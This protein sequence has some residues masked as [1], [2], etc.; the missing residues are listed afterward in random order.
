[1]LTT[2][3]GS[4]DF[5]DTYDGLGDQLDE[6]DDAFNDDT[7]GGGEPAA[8]GKKPVGKDFDFFGHTAKVSDAI[9]E[10]QL[11][12]SRQAPVSRVTPTT[13]NFS[14]PPSKPAR[15]GYE[16]YKEPEY[17]PD[18]QVDASLW[19]VAPKQP[20]PA[21]VQ[22]SAAASGP[23]SGG[24]KMM[25]LEE[26]EAA[27]RAQAKKPAQPAPQAPAQNYAGPPQPQ[28]SQPP[29][30]YEQAYAQQRHQQHPAQISG[31]TR[32]EPRAAHAGQPVQPVQILQRSQAPPSQPTPPAGP[33]QPTQ[34]LQNPNRH[35]GEQQRATP[36]QHSHHSR[37]SGSRNI[38]THP[39]QLAALSEVERNAFL[40]EDAKRAKR[41]HKIFLL[42]KDNG[43]MTPQDKNFITRIQLQQLVTA[44]G[45][46]NEHS[47]DAGLSEDFYYQVH[48]QI[49]GGPRQHPGQPLSNFAQ[50]Y[51][52]QTGGRHGGMRRQARGGDNHMQRMEQ[53]VQ[54]AVEAAKNKPKNKQLVIEGS[55]GKISFSNAKT[56]KPLLNIKRA[57]SGAD[58]NRPGSAAR[59]RKAHLAGVSGSDRKTVLTDIENVYNTLMQMEDHDRHIPPPLSD[60]IDPELVGRHMD[61]REM[62]L[63]LNQQLWKQL[64][65]HEPIGATT[66][67]PFIAFLSFSKGKKAIPRVFRHIT[68]EQRTTILTMI[69]L[70]LDQLDVV[71]NGQPVSGETQLNA[72]L[73]ENVDLFSS[74]VMPSLFQY[75]SEADLDIVTGVLGLILTINVDVVARSRV[76]V[77]M[78]TM[79]LSR[80]ELIKQGGASNEQ[81]WDQW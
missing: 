40:M 76:G 37:P 64:K 31:L 59:D 73:R 65:V 67:H 51:L 33:S 29:Q 30:Q 62:G 16:R 2:S 46:P 52:F 19:G 58:G 5:E 39:G 22:E 54:R 35:S 68:Q 28:Y 75:L 21:F 38:I 8:I 48:N 45:N 56:P 47:T 44:T 20:A 34:I 66:I 70:H 4:L 80:A 71:R 17:V 74:A 57:E 72:S 69:V 78:L 55:L 7:F 60:E 25:S 79:I 24:R 9:N 12:Y 36:P 18:M 43:L 14:K 10:E 61:W 49:R 11:R 81:E 13:S 41:N 42:S 32:E 15:S 6:T 23:S 63:K 53:Q 1:M 77:S 50:T 3:F 27:M 26:V